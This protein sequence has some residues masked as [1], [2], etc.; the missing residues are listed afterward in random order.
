MPKGFYRELIAILK[1]RGCHFVRTGKGDHEIWHSPVSDKNFTV[2]RSCLSRHT[3]NAVLG[4]AGI[5][6]QF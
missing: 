6:K 3:A 5:E 4:Q 1:A 2:D